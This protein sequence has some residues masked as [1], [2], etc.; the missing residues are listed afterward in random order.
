MTKLAAWMAVILLAAAGTAFAQQNQILHVSGNSWEDGGFPPSTA[1]DYYS[2]VG[3]LNDIEFPLTW[4]TQNYSYTWYAHELVSNGES[5]YGNTHVVDY[6]GGQFTIYVDF[7]PS[8]HNYGI[9]PP[10]ATVPGTFTDGISIYLDGDFTDF[11]LTFND[12]TQS[13]SFTGTLNFTGGDVYNLLYTTEGWTFGA[14][15]AGVSPE[16]YD[17]EVNGD[18][19]LAIVSVEDQTWGGIKALYH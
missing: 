8:N 6:T 18:V 15:L 1:G 7:L 12:L 4:D 2:I 5:I 10:N 13:G 14:N 19:F 9:N 17:L 11:S 3:I 16:G